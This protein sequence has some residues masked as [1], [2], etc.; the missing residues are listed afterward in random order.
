MVKY[1][2]I[3]KWRTELLILSILFPKPNRHASTHGWQKYVSVLCGLKCI[4]NEWRPPILDSQA[5]TQGY[6][7]SDCLQPP[8]PRFSPLPPMYSVS[9]LEIPD[10]TI[11]LCQ[12]LKNSMVEPFR[13]WVLEPG[14]PEPSFH[15]WPALW[16][17]LIHLSF[18]FLLFVFKMWPIR[19]PTSYEY[20]WSVDKLCPL[21][22]TLWTGST[23]GFPV[24]QCLL[25]FA[26]IHVHWVSD[27]I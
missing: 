6:S 13:I 23:P 5:C 8:Q 1:I 12:G 4:F 9:V 16:S 7:W 19:V 24:L 2:I 14:C 10:L 3:K 18:L 20:C 22:A 15:H 26:Q 27:A 11:H 17:W 21:F 25:E